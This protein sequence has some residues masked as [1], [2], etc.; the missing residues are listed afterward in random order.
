VALRNDLMPQSVIN[1]NG[2]VDEYS[3]KEKDLQEKL[4]R[5]ED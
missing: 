3:D 4:W 2:Q 1:K 5:T